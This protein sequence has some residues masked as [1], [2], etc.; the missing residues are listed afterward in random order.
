[1]YNNQKKVINFD[2]SWKQK[3]VCLFSSISIFITS[4]QILNSKLKFL[5]C[6][7]KS[8]SNHNQIYTTQ[9]LMRPDSPAWLY[10][11]KKRT[12]L[13][14][15]IKQSRKIDFF[16][17]IKNDDIHIW[18]LRNNWNMKLGREFKPIR[19]LNTNCFSSFNKKKEDI[20]VLNI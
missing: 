1:M 17:D 16:Y 14:F 5:M 15:C 3:I 10:L 6:I 7:L 18:L 11:S 19:I 9:S 13:I 12:N 20:Y 8:G 4:N 2:W